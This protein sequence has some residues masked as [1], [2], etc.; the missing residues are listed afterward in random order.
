MTD[1]ESQLRR[2]L[3]GDPKDFDALRALAELVG[4]ARDR[5]AEAVELWRRYADVAGP[6][7]A[8]GA[9]FALGRAQV[10]ARQEAD[11]IETL[12]VCT[13][14]DPALSEAFDLLGELLR[15]AGRLEEAVEELKRAADLDPEAVRPR[16]A[17]A[18]CY[19]ALGRRSEAESV[20]SSLGQAAANDPAVS[21]LVRELMHRRA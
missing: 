3:S 2:R 21:A 9:L 4:A 15:R 13:R 14:E 7:L 10:E 6:E 11:A 8:G 18:I 5:K 1:Q 17:L 16:V 19:D 12:L 20:L